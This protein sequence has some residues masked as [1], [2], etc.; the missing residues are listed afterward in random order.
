M[1]GISQ[2]KDETAEASLD[3]ILNTWMERM[4]LVTN[5]EKRKLLAL[6]IT[7]L[8]TANSAV[9]QSKMAALIRNVVETL[10]DITD[11]SETGEQVE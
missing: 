8:M 7:S 9:V 4:P 10:N 11:M 2:T 6:A 5:N 3:R 1:G